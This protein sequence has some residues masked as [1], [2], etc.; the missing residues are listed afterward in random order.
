[1][2]DEIKS[3]LKPLWEI[4][5]NLNFPDPPA[6][7]LDDEVIDRSKEFDIDFDPCSGDELRELMCQVVPMAADLLNA[8]DVGIINH[9]IVLQPQKGPAEDTLIGREDVGLILRAN[10]I[11]FFIE[12]VTVEA[13]DVIN[14]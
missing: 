5:W 7:N 12:S 4:C 6:V 8:I 14:N 9:A 11:A 2:P 13:A 1:M 3:D 10:D